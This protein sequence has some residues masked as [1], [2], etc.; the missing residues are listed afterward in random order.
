MARKGRR[1][2][3]NGVLQAGIESFRSPD[4]ILGEVLDEMLPTVP[5]SAEDRCQRGYSLRPLKATKIF[6]RC[7]DMYRV[8]TICESPLGQ[9][10]MVVTDRT[11]RKVLLTYR[12]ERTNEGRYTLRDGRR[13]HASQSR[14]RPTPAALFGEPDGERRRCGARSSICWSGAHDDQELDGGGL[15][16]VARSVRG[17]FGVDAREGVQVIVHDREAADRDGEDF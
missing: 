10:M 4:E 6:L 8:L 11:A 17:D 7:Q 13:G 5:I 14:L 12:V 16:I 15:P 3:N 2:L 9:V 1:A